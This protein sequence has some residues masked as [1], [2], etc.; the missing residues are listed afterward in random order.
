MRGILTDFQGS[1]N[2][3]STSKT[4]KGFLA[5]IFEANLGISIEGYK[6]YVSI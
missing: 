5:Q 1:M 4:A 2:V 3:A 6:S